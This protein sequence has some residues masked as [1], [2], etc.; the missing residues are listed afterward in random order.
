MP[1][2]LR[3][4]DS[5]RPADDRLT[6]AATRARAA[7]AGPPACGGAGRRSGQVSSVAINAAST[8]GA[9]AAAAKAAGL[10]EAQR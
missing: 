6:N 10:A 7:A 1:P 3:F 8:K 5:G 9:M 4:G 2:S